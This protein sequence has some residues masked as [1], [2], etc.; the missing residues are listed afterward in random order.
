MRLLVQAGKAI[1]SQHQAVCGSVATSDWLA[2]ALN[3]PEP[4]A[5]WRSDTRVAAS[6]W[7]AEA[8]SL[9]EPTAST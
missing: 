3:L 4:G 2:E 6:S 1:S 5:G 8:L 9:P 7:L